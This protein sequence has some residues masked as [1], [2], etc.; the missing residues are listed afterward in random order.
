MASD[1]F[2]YFQT[3]SLMITFF[4]NMMQFSLVD[5][6]THFGL[7]HSSHFLGRKVDATQNSFQTEVYCTRSET[8]ATGIM[9]NTVTLG[10]CHI[11]DNN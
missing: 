10:Q 1:S 6:Y 8:L 7:K 3:K 11:Q 2:T 9:K 4:L 5:S